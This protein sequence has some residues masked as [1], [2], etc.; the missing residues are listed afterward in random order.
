M[1]LQA[2]LGWYCTRR[3]VTQ[4]LG[5][6]FVYVRSEAKK[7][8]MT[9]LIEGVIE[10]GQSVVVIE[11]LISTGGSSLKAVEALREAGAVVKV[12]GGLCYL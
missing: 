10:A 8:G 9:N 2:L 7:H 1:L 6:P 3:L 5:L 11:D 12:Y 4:E